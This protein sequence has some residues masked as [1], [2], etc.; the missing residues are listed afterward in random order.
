MIADGF[1]HSLYCTLLCATSVSSLISYS[2]FFCGGQ[3]P[4]GYTQ[5]P[6]D[7][8]WERSPET[9][10]SN[11]L[12]PALGSLWPHSSLTLGNTLVL[13]SATW[14]VRNQYSLVTATFDKGGLVAVELF[15]LTFKWIFGVFSEHL[16][17]QSNPT[18]RG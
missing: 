4:A 10:V 18:H 11:L 13:I 3:C 16:W 5:P 17:E 12:L 9:L 2:S 1:P 14:N 6:L 8:A 15:P 7:A